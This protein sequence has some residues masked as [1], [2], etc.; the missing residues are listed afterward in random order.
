M[1]SRAKKPFAVSEESGY[2][3]RVPLVY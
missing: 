2:R 1:P 3:R